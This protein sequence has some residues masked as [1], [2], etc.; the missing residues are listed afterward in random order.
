MIGRKPFSVFHSSLKP[1][2]I[3]EA[4]AGTGKTYNITGLFL[5][6][7]ISEGLT[8]DR[9][10]VVTFTRMATKELKERILRQLRQALSAIESGNTGEDPLIDELCNVIDNTTSAA[11]LI[12]GAVRNFDDANIYTIHGFC[13]QILR[14]ETLLSGAPVDM[15]V[16]Q[17]DG[18]LDEAAEDFWRNFIDSHSDSRTGRYLIDKMEETGSNP[19]ELLE[20]IKPAL[21]Y[22]A[23]LSE[24]AGN[25]APEPFIEAL[26]EKR[27]E[28][29]KLWR[30]QRVE[31]MEELSGS[32][33][34]RMTKKAVAGFAVKM[35]RFLSESW[36]A[37]DSFT[38]MKYFTSSYHTGNLKKNKTTL[39]NHIFFQLCDEYENLA[40]D[41]PLVST[42]LLE[43][44]SVAIK[45]LRNQKGRESS[46]YTYDDLLNA[47]SEALENENKGS[48]LAKKL[49]NKYPFALVD[50]FQDTDPVQ[51]RIFDQIY[52]GESEN[53]SLIMIG[54]PKQSIYA[55]RGADIYSYISARDAVPDA[56]VFT[57]QKNFRSTP[58]LIKALNIFFN[59]EHKTP[60]LSDEISYHEIEAGRHSGDASYISANQESVPLNIYCYR[61]HD[62]KGQLKP[63][64]F[65]EAA[66]QV[67][68][69]IEEGR[70][71]LRKIS[72]SK[73][74]RNIESGDIAVLVHSHR[75]AESVKD[76]LKSIGVGAV[77]YSREKVFDSRE[78][79]RIE[80]LLS[81]V[82]NPLSR[83]AVQSAVVSGF[84]GISLSAMYEYLNSEKEYLKLSEIL[85]DL[86]EEWRSKGSYPMMRKI[87]FRTG[88][89]HHVSK[90][91]NSE[92]VVTNIFQLTE[93]MAKAETD[94]ELDPPAML[95]WFRS[96]ITENTVSDEETI[97]LE[98]DAN[99]VKISTIHNS[100]GLEFPVVFCPTLWEGKD[101]RTRSKLIETCHRIHAPYER[102]I[103]YQQF[104]SSERAE[105][106]DQAHFEEIA[107][108]VRKAYVALTR[109]KYECRI[110]WG[111]TDTSHLSGLGAMLKGKEVIRKS[112]I[113][114]LKVGKND[115]LK[116]DD[117]YHHFKMLA[118]KHPEYIRLHTPDTSISSP[119]SLKPV[120]EE[121]QLSVRNYEGPD[122]IDRSK[123]LYS[124]TSLSGHHETDLDAPDYD[125]Y[126]QDYLHYAM[127]QSVSISDA[128]DIFQFPK[129]KTA[130]TFIHKLFE[131]EK[132][133]FRSAELEEEVLRE[134][135]TDF[136][137]DERWVKVL[138]QMMLNVSNAD[139]GEFK[140][141][142]VSPD[143]MLKEME[144]YFPVSDLQSGDI[145]NLIRGNGTQNHNNGTN[146]NFMKGFI[147]LVARQNDKYYIVD[148]K[149]NY[150]GDKPRN[151]SPDLLKNEILKSNYDIQ[152]YLYTVALV[153]YLKQR[154]PGFN[155]RRSFGGVF[156]LFV[157][158]IE[159][160]ESNGIYFDL[161]DEGLIGELENHLYQKGWPDE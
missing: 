6:L 104:A 79:E 55:F 13:Q 3:I 110:F 126:L 158:G 28:I 24:G 78:A 107:E 48:L 32:D 15:E 49:R 138:N 144:F 87:L 66:R 121:S 91:A 35:D 75:D 60:F 154:V 64:I 109:A 33:V 77:T 61:Q 161:P 159:E 83:T 37:K 150:L 22:S 82:L 20:K 100:K 90:L 143:Q 31:I 52:P 53:S 97:R 29:S 14:E 130:G 36:P 127:H 98:S 67:K 45:K 46:V 139:Y 94:K 108:E 123:R 106:T 151:Y 140:L 42:W 155:Y 9:I 76:L 85:Q 80:Q 135:L 56:A 88:G 58:G 50:E 145:K 125:Q 65:M 68:E 59:P 160:K 38:Q 44:A 112:I 93:L 11:E 69:L 142:Q 81:A 119:G 103:N 157:R 153:K 2:M 34:K 95:R 118:D 102:V 25:F 62:T 96:K 21:N 89:L 147:D 23:D 131:H 101:F 51:Y 115:Q 92:R 105:A 73:Q 12:R 10:L 84:F 1:R 122:E 5:R 74:A 146:T 128:P 111:T 8:L 57:L 72:G 129:G 148:Y 114:K 19:A 40:A 18:L 113:K 71:G 120:Y 149:S 134:M 7:L 116:S 152:Y 117:F 26:L 54:D 4:S 63:L 156:Y 124:F 17:S 47:V 30:D 86:N 16:S 43:K 137:F 133:D 27:E 41:I 136:G 132:F 141:N 99:L 39:P 70:N